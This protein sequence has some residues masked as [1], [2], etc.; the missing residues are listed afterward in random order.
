MAKTL[1]QVEKT[2]VSKEAREKA[3]RV[4]LE[5]VKKEI[6]LLKIEQRAMQKASKANKGK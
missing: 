1:L 6:K 4:S 3:L 5:A 2:I